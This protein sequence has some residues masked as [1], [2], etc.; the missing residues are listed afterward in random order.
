MDLFFEALT[1]MP[2]Q[3]NSS[4]SDKGSMT[5]EQSHDDVDTD[6]N[7][8]TANMVNDEIIDS[9]CEKIEACA[10]SSKKYYINSSW[11][12][13]HKSH[14]R[15][16]A[17]A[18]GISPKLIVEVAPK[19][20]EIVKTASSSKTIKTAQV[21]EAEEAV[22]SKKDKNHS[23]LVAAL[24]DPFHIEERA[25]TDHMEKEDWQKISSQKVISDKPSILQNSI[26][27]IRSSDRYDKNTNGII[28]S[29][30]N[31]IVDPLIID[32]LA[33][34]KSED[35]GQRLKKQAENRRLEKANEHKQWEDDV[36][37]SMTHKD[38][39]AKG[40]VFPTESMVAQSGLDCPASRRIANKFDSSDIPAKTAGEMIKDQNAAYREQI[41]R[42]K[43]K[44]EWEIPS[45]ESSREVSESF[46]ESLKKQL[47]IK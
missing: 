8:T 40:R 6:L 9:E 31:S 34:S 11:D 25:N 19:A 41:K 47:K 16:Y 4:N 33:N 10:S 21:A 28:A 26:V 17:C 30:Q 3:A 45:R 2:S 24:G 38:I 20:K 27:P 1:G 35:T 43:E 29:N 32:K 13:S 7:M 42:P 36:I 22:I 18:M 15:E 39:V 5:V 44:N 14:L 46:V 12:S 37:K 23:L